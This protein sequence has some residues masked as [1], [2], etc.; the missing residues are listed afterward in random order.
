MTPTCII[1]VGLLATAP[2]PVIPPRDFVEYWSAA[3]VHATGGDPYDGHQLLPYQRLAAGDPDKSQAT[4][5]WTPPWTLP[6]YLPFGMLDPRTAHLL[7]LVVQAGCVLL[8]SWLL[9]RVYGGPTGML[10]PLVPLAAAAT[11]A[12]VWWLIGFGQNTGF[13]LLGLAGYLYL[14]TRGYPVAAGIAAAL[15]AV[16]PH[17]LV[18]FGL[19]L[20]LDAATRPG[21]RALLSGVVTLLISSAVALLPNPDVFGQFSAA[22]TRP[23]SAE[24]PALSE[25]KVP[26]VGSYVRWWIDPAHGRPFWVQFVPL[27][28]A[29]VALVPY[30]WF[31][32]RTWDWSVETPRLVFAS[33]LAAPYGAWMFDLTVLLA[34]VVPAV[35]LLARSPRLVPVTAAAGSHLLLL[36][37]T[38][39]PPG[40]YQRWFGEPLSLHHFVWFTPAVL[41]W[42][43]AVV[44]TSRSAVTPV[45]E[46]RS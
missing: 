32:R 7:W 28:A 8:S 5:L 2:E 14:R 13:V 33:V 40:R 21:R 20:V 23:H 4:M 46:A 43:L 25:W 17:L 34:P 1:A 27:A 26:V 41:V 29:C 38:F 19:A 11:F 44:A 31:R 22:L 36:A 30:W 35:A 39:T 12:P 9:W 37:L 10:W 24:A 16:K 45:S 6:L 42:F 15:T 18:L 3:R